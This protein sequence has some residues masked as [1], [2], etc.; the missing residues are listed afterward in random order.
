MRGQSQAAS[1]SAATDITA[2]A[3]GRFIAALVLLIANDHWW[4]AEY[5]N[6]LTGKLSD[7]V[8][9][10]MLP[11][12]IVCALRL[13]RLPAPLA[14]VIAVTGTWFA[15]IKVWPTAAAS[16]ETLAETLTGVE[17][18]IIVDPTDLIGLAG[19][20]VATR[21]VAAPRPIISTKVVRVGLLALGL[22]ATVATSQGYSS[23]VDDLIVDDETGEV[24][25][26]SGLS[27]SDD[28]VFCDDEPV[29][30]DSYDAEADL[31]LDAQT[32]G[33]DQL[34]LRRPFECRQPVDGKSQV[35]QF[36][37]SD[38]LDDDSQVCVR[39]DGA[40][41]EVTTDGSTWNTEWALDPSSPST[42][43]VLTRPNHHYDPVVRDI[44]VDRWGTT[45]VSYNNSTYVT[46]T[47]AGEWSP[48][49]SDFRPIGTVYGAAIFT[50]VLSMLA[51]TF[52]R[53]RSKRWWVVPALAVAAYVAVVYGML[54]G[55]A[56]IPAGALASV[57]FYSLALFITAVLVGRYHEEIPGQ[58]INVGLAFGSAAL[59]IFPFLYWKYSAAASFPSTWTWLGIA[60][61][62]GYAIDAL[63]GRRIAA[64]P[65]PPP[66]QPADAISPAT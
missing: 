35:G 51:A 61:V 50:M 44:I 14:P 22:G 29:S 7:V 30:D 62:S 13:S 28:T 57:A 5:G 34:D 65:M 47:E 23:S 2:L 15:A 41:I 45:H 16:T 64:Q 25:V 3:D 66:P 39:A 54:N 26:V 19:L 63:I 43:G 1:G 37:R 33:T 38:C 6:W 20:Y 48:P 32:S 10:I 8:G 36:N 60:A 4:K 52:R 27:Y 42:Y 59:V 17:H 21:I 49:F 11:V 9:L 12:V 56:V 31:I 55:E 58:W 40:A 46:R 18:Q 53:S 24:S